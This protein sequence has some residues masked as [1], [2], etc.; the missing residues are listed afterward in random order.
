MKMP[1]NESADKERRRGF[2]R[3]MG[4]FLKTPVFG[5]EAAPELRFLEQL[6]RI[7]PQEKPAVR[8]FSFF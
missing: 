3:K 2:S 4:K 7:F 8:F 6:F 5:C 1:A